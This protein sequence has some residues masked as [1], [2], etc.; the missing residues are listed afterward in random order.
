MNPKDAAFQEENRDHI[1]IKEDVSQTPLLDTSGEIVQQVHDNN[2]DTEEDVDL[3]LSE[4]EES[5]AED[6][7]NDDY[8]SDE[9]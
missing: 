8:F 7:E 1:E 2:E 6:V 9:E 5:E 4:N 3:V